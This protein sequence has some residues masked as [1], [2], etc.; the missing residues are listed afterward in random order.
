MWNPSN[1]SGSQ[2]QPRRDDPDV[3][4][5]DVEGEVMRCTM[6]LETLKFQPWFQT[7]S[8]A[9]LSGRQVVVTVSRHGRLMPDAHLTL[10]KMVCVAMA[11]PPQGHRPPHGTTIG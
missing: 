5:R 3:P 4:R 7:F 6:D 1:A 2:D 10:R 11:W 9:F 8:Q